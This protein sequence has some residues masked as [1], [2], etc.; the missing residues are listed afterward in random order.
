MPG[1]LHKER[2]GVLEPIDDYAAQS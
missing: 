1:K 2:Y